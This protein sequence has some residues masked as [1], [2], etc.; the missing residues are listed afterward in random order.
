M[1]LWN[2]VSRLFVRLIF[3]GS[4]F[5]VPIISDIGFIISVMGL[6]LKDLHVVTL[7][8]AGK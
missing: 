7:L 4:K 3:C 6:E 1:V 5:N 8:R 2:I